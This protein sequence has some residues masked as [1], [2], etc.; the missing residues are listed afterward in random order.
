MSLRSTSVPVSTDDSRTRRS[1]RA[2]PEA[3]ENSTTDSANP[4]SSSQLSKVARVSSTSR[5]PALVDISNSSGL[6]Q[7]VAGIA[8]KILRPHKA[9]EKKRGNKRSA[10][11]EES[12]EEDEN[13]EDEQ[14]N[15][16]LSVV[17]APGEASKAKEKSNAEL[18]AEWEARDLASQSVENSA[19]VFNHLRASETKSL[20]N[21]K[22]MDK[23]QA[24]LSFSMR[25]ILIDWLVEVAEEYSL[26]CQTLFLAVAYVDRFLDKVA[27]DRS[28]LQ[29]VGVTAMLLAAKYWEIYPPSI[30]DF[31]Y[32]SDHTYSRDEVVE[33]ESAILATLKFG[34][35]VPTPWDFSKKF[36]KVAQL[37][38]THENQ[39]EYMMELFL[40]ESASLLYKPSLI[41]ASAVFLSLWNSHEP[42]WN[43]KMANETGFQLQEIQECVRDLQAVL[44]KNYQAINSSPSSTEFNH[45]KAVREK[46][47]HEKFLAVATLKPRFN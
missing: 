1:K 43:V 34:L 39:V 27:I 3:D 11:E 25:A 26:Q 13:E 5:R 40:M 32:I 41:A 17:H 31:V 2:A 8:D 30:E 28:K 23:V 9:G 7:A 35:T 22:Y 15:S 47:S 38:K 42:A 20:P 33:M 46:F 21:P 6:L 36:G 4:S 44:I 19:L 14:G 16:L 45:L 29:L 37:S 12:I 24:D 10:K 18:I